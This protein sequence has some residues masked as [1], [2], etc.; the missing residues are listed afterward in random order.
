MQKEMCK[1]GLSDKLSKEF[2]NIVPESKENV[3]VLSYQKKS[4]LFTK[5]FPR[6]IEGVSK[7]NDK[8]VSQGIAEEF[9]Q[10][11]GFQ[12]ISKDIPKALSKEFSEKM[13][14]DI[15]TVR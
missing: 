3:Y 7:G 1:V 5:Y 10:H 12:E 14:K 8:G 4:R 6:I 15:E 13:P 2:S 9:L 11:N